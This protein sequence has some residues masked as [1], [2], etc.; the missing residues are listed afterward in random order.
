MGKI[1][2]IQLRG[3]SR[4]PSD[5]T[6]E[7]GGVAESLNT[8][9]DAGEVAP[10][11]EPKDITSD[12]DI[13]DIKGVERV[14]IHKTPHSENYILAVREDDSTLVIGYCV[15]GVFKEI[16][17]LDRDE[18]I[19]GITSIGNTVVMSTTSSL[20]YILYGGGEY[21]YL[22]TKIPQPHIEFRCIADNRYSEASVINLVSDSNGTLESGIDL[23]N[24]NAWE[25]A[26][27][28]I[29]RNTED[30]TGS[31]ERLL[32]LQEEVWSNI[33]KRVKGNRAAGYFTMP[34][35]VRYAV[36]LY[37]GSYIH[38]SVP[39]LLGAGFDKFVE[40]TGTKTTTSSGSISTYLTIKPSMAFSATANL[41]RWDKEGWEETIESI[42]IFVSTDVSYPAFSSN[43]SKIEM[44]Y[45]GSEV[46]DI[47]KYSMSFDNGD[48][49][50]LDALEKELMSK[51]LFYK[52]ASFRTADLKKLEDGFNILDADYPASQD[53]LMEYDRL[54]DYELSGT[55]IIPSELFTFNNRII[56]NGAKRA[57]PT[58][59]SFLQS[60]NI[61]KQ[62]LRSTERSFAYFVPGGDGAM[63]K[64]IS[65]SPNGGSLLTPYG[66]DTSDEGGASYS[67]AESYGLI[68]YPDSRCES[69]EMWHP[70]G[71]VI[72]IAM[73]PHPLL[74][75]SYAFWG[76]SKT[77]DEYV[78]QVA[79]DV[80]LG[81]FTSNEN[82]YEDDSY[83]VYQS[84]VNNPF[85]FP[86]TGV[87]TLPARVLGIATAT[88]ALSQ[89]QFGQ[90]PLYVFT[91]DGIW[92]METAS[93]GSLVSSK[94]LS[95]EV[96]SNPASITP[97]D[98]AVLFMSD[99][100]LMLLQ[101]SQISE[102]S[103]YMNGKH[104]TINE[105]AKVIISGQPQFSGLIDAVTDS[106][107]F[108][109]FMKDAEIGYD[110][111]GKRIICFNRNEIYQ[112]VYKFDTNTWHKIYHSSA[113]TDASPL[114]SYPRCEVVAKSITGYSRIID[115]STSLEKSDDRRAERGVIV[116]RPF[117][118]DEPDVL[119]TITDVR[120]RGQ[121]APRAYRFILQ[122]SMDNI[123]WYTIS[124]LRGKAWK[125]FRI[126]LLTDL[127][128][129]ERISWI[130]IM[131]DSRFT[132]RL[133]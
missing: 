81:S 86:L 102:L 113:I 69:V 66:M 23:F 59:Y 20:H 55:D 21:R 79:S 41:V 28:S 4:T 8:Y 120:V 36:R 87:N 43:F 121:F 61:I 50:D 67:Y 24:I 94:P 47:D 58:G 82:K 19:S 84:E 78:S 114:N 60:T 125:M 11:L 115:Y 26:I 77:L 29:K 65:R 38:Q 105:S 3:I 2:R 7:D 72:T 18:N 95:R 80:T 75:C 126:I 104:Y 112:Y 52:I 14:F 90:F 40:I 132:N 48:L 9:L 35:F 108:M 100:G 83:K 73:R 133:R 97:I 31:K 96:C 116:T 33:N 71:D 131:Y 30:N 93:D 37:D 39:I 56:A 101:G 110:Y 74:N 27:D 129:H 12:L 32:E 128:V 98:Q 63:H 91:E 5:R 62:G 44:T 103:P 111:Q 22:G 88:T 25:K 51:S 107:P 42:D 92:A 119:K 118:L 46:V 57:L 17:S 68:F 122:G 70:S 76:L 89:G 34:V 15:N 127:N 106:T 99:K 16:V 53:T 45:D 123:T 1:K 13:P 130:D 64:I 85:Y 6:T 54:P 109:T 117:D 10:V 49:S 124:T